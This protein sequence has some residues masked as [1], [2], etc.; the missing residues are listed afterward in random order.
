MM[1][2]MVHPKS[3]RAEPV[4]IP[5]RPP[6]KK[7]MIKRREPLIC[8][9]KYGKSAIH[10]PSPKNRALVPHCSTLHQRQYHLKR[11]TR[12]TMLIIGCINTNPTIR[13]KCLHRMR[14]LG[15]VNTIQI[16]R[17]INNHPPL[18]IIIIIL[19]PPKMHK[20]PPYKNNPETNSS[21]AHS[22]QRPS[23]EPP[24]AS[25]TNPMFAKI[26]KRLDFAALATRASIYT[27]GGIPRR[28]GRW[29]RSTKRRRSGMK[30]RRARRW[31]RL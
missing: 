18:I 30:I 13:L 6:R 23:Y 20:Y 4:A 15:L 8:Y 21:P 10:L 2:M 29:S 9:S 26:T 16:P 3:A 5:P 28:D 31:R 27:I 22:A 14:Q 24:Y 1:H 19:H 25:I 7:T 17:L 11:R 12:E